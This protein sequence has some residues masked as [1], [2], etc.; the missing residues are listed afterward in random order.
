M[1]YLLLPFHMYTIIVFLI[2][3]DTDEC[4]NSLKVYKISNMF[5]KVKVHFGLRPMGELNLFLY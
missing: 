3:A 4:D 2:T 5:K 1:H